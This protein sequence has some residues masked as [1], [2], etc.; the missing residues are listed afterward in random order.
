MLADSEAFALD[1]DLGGGKILTAV[2]DSQ[3][4]MRSI[5]RGLA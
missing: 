1:I 5:N 2:T 3:G 4:N